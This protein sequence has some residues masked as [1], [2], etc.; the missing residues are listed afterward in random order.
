MFPFPKIFRTRLLAAV[1]FGSMLPAGYALAQ[2][3]CTSGSF[4]SAQICAGGDDTSTIYINGNLLGNILY[5]NWDGSGACNAKCLPV[6]LSAFTMGASVCLAVKTQNLRPD[7]NYSSWSLD[8]N[9]S[10]N[11]S[12][13]T[14][15]GG[16]GLQLYYHNDGTTNTPDPSPGPNGIPW[17]A[18][19]Y[20]G[21]L[22]NL[23][24]AVV[25]GSVWGQPVYNPV[26][27]A[28][29][30]PLANNSLGD[31]STGTGALFWRQCAVLPTP[32]PTV[33]P[34]N[35]TINKVMVGQPAF[36][37]P[38]QGQVSVTYR[39]TLCDSGAPVTS[40]V[41]VFDHYGSQLNLAGWQWNGSA[42]SYSPPVLNASDPT[43]YTSGP[44]ASAVFPLGLPGGGQCVTLG[45]AFVD[46]SA[47]NQGC[48]AVT[49]DANA[50]WNGGQTPHTNP[51]VFTIPCAGATSTPTF[52]PTPTPTNTLTPTPSNTPTGTPTPTPTKTPTPTFSPTWTFTPLSSATPTSTPTNTL[53]FTPPDTPT[54]T[55]TPTP[56]ATVTPT[57]T[58]TDTP[59]V[60]DTSTPTATLTDTATPTATFTPTNT[61][62]RT[63]TFTP[64]DTPT[65]TDTSTPTATLT[66]TATPTATFTSTNTATRTATYTPTLTDTPT[67]TMTPTPTFTPTPTP[68]P[69]GIHKNVAPQAVQ[70]GGL[71]TYTLQVDVAANSVD[72]VVVTDTLPA[73]V[74][75]AAFSSSPSGTTTSFNTATSQLSWTLP[76]PLSRG[77]YQLT[78][79]TQVNNFVPGGT[80]IT[81]GAQLTF[82]GLGTPLTASASATVVGQFT[83]RIAIY[84][85]AG[86][87]VK[88][89]YLQQLSQPIN[90]IT[91]QSSDAITTLHGAD[92]AVTAY[93]QGIPIAVWDGTASSGDPVSNGTY[94]LKV[95]NID[96]TGVA[97]ST[98]QEV[99]VSRTLAKASILIY[100]EAG[101]E[102]KT[103][104]AYLDD[105]GQNTLRN[106]QLSSSVIAPGGQGGGVPDHLTIV[107]STGTAVVW[108]GTGNS[109]A[110]LRN[111]QYFVE[112]HTTDGNGIEA[113]VVKQVSVVGRSVG[114]GLGVVSASPNVVRGG[115]AVVTFHNNS[116]LSLGMR[117]SLYTVDGEWVRA[118]TG[119]NDS[120]PP[121]LDAGSLAS[122][123]YLAVVELNSADGGTMD[124]QIVKITVIH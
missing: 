8:V 92:N 74:S 5:C 38:S 4:V 81:N 35:V 56:T 24:P 34:P 44:P 59:T 53:T 94:Y 10:G 40:P 52:T 107:L 9:C 11:H 1:V 62:T 63:P 100:N 48:Q 82:P 61:A 49:N 95:D 50:T 93:Y 15:D 22:F 21:G 12:V 123:L 115:S 31:Y 83:V 27:G 13:I 85:E 26:T 60:T 19:G 30:S 111:G 64:T 70:A 101:E 113:T 58:P 90:S 65:I 98:T 118:A 47:A 72:G 122:G 121:R 41:T 18:P 78:Y 96:S 97:N 42:W 80:V 16:S 46:Y 28:R 6:P 69:V 39:I 110:Y 109:G 54:A 73:N 36:N 17:Y 79:Q 7:I 57:F 116:G 76:S 67:D 77:T 114:A 45:I 29:V 103:L 106:V 51:V 33:G 105:T 88:Q 2:S 23:T 124:R 99:T 20:N 25:T 108:D 68:T 91:L 120:N 117:V 112:V 75:F 84:N 119:D 71:L 66:D 89:I 32:Q 14:S 43:G 3:P 86:E 87:V 102:V 37:V 55:F 104:Y